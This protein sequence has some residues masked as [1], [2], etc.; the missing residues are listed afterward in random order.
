M[1]DRL[2]VRILPGLTADFTTE[3]PEVLRLLFQRLMD[4]ARCGAGLIGV[5]R[6]ALYQRI[7]APVLTAC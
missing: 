2:P 4:T 7:I 1:P 5:S 6:L 3:Y